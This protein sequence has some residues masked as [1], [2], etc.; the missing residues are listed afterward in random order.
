MKGF[1]ANV[2][3]DLNSEQ[4]DKYS[5]SYTFCMF[6]FLFS[7]YILC[8][9]IVPDDTKC[10]THCTYFREKKSTLA[11]GHK[12]QGGQH[13]D[14]GGRFVEVSETGVEVSENG[15]DVTELCWVNVGWQ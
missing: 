1:L 2:R 11:S 12:R 13:G 5:M 8:N 14:R 4:L 10:I 15:I 9:M 7:G 3:A 6:L